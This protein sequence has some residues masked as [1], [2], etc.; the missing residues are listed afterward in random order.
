MKAHIIVIN[1]DE[2]LQ[3]MMS[4]LLHRNDYQVTRHSYATATLANLL[5]QQ[6]DLIILD[7]NK[8]DSGLEWEFLQMLK[9][10]E[11][12]AYIPILIMAT[13]FQLSMEV[14]NYLLT[15]YINIIYKPLELTSVLQL[16]EQTLTHA[17]QAGVIFSSD[18]KL[19]ILVVDDTEELLE[20]T[21]TVLMLE[22]YQVV[23]A[24]NGLVAL[25]A[26]SHAEHCLIL[27]DIAMPVMNGF[28]FIDAYNRQLRPHSPVII[29]S[30]EQNI[31]EQRLPSFVVDILSKPYKLP[32]LLNLVQK[33][34][35]LA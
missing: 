29:L 16:I 28:E 4:Q 25:D 8:A 19:P 1:N 3:K 17:S 30:A 20:S 11:T 5:M 35:R 33:Y 26:V 32:R 34:A 31:Q 10:E 7:F 15:R 6:P 23:S 2:A 22:G 12:T 24:T 14:Q 21:I 27:L 13:P 18:R 9:M